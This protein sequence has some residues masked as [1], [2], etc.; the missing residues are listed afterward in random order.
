MIDRRKQ[1]VGPADAAAFVCVCA[2]ARVRALVYYLLILST[3]PAFLCLT[4]VGQKQTGC[5]GITCSGLRK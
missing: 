3:E 5:S 2:R 1:P 4:V